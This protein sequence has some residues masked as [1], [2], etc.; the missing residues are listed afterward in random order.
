MHA[1]AVKKYFANSQHFT[2][3]QDTKKNMLS[4]RIRPRKLMEKL[5]Q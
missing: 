2:Y 4:L 3:D 1:L 5:K